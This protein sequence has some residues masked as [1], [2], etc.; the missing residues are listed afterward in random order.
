MPTEHEH[1]TNCLAG[2]RCP[3][4]QSYGPYRIACTTYVR[5]FDDGSDSSTGVD[6]SPESQCRCSECNH[7][8]TVQDFTVLDEDEEQSLLNALTMQCYGDEKY[9]RDT[10]LE[11]VIRREGR[12]FAEDFWDNFDPSDLKGGDSDE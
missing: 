10:L 9:M 4:C 7:A 6:W 12:P 3:K 5:M 11:H 2:L 1:N 8:A